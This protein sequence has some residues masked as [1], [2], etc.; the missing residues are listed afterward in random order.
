MSI[1]IKKSFLDLILPIKCLGCKKEGIPICQECLAKLKY[2]P[3]KCFVCKKWT[4]AQKR[5]LAG[6]TCSS[7]RPH[8]PIH[9][10]FSPLSYQDE[11]V[12]AAIHSLKYNRNTLL[13][14][15]FGKLIVQY[16]K[17]HQIKFSKN[18]IFIP[19]P[20]HRRRE[21]YRGFNQSY[22]IAK[23][24]SK[25][26]AIPCTKNLV[27]KVSPTPPQV[28][29]DR[30]HRLSNLHNAFVVKYPQKITNQH[31]ILID[32]VTTTGATLNEIGLLLKDA[33]AK[34]VSALTVAH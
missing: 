2:I 11:L 23:E 3:P 4:T 5:T 16:L 18:S 7:C 19:V 26:I 31:I 13:A 21:K 1:D 27:E 6:R 12:C 8:T 24:I 29:L 33:G 14:Q 28:E 10:F 15:V 22:L 9:S 34:Y 30:E 32:D 25:Y 17:Q 20:L